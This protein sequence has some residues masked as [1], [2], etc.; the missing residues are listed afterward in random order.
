MPEIL[1]IEDDL[2]FAR[3]V[4]KIMTPHGYVIHHAANGLDGL[5]LARQIT[6]DIILLDMHL[7]DLDGKAIVVTLRGT[8]KRGT[9]PIVALTA[10][11]GDRAKRIALALGCEYFIS[12]PIDTRAFPGQIGAIIESAHSEAK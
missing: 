10:E 12:K 5:R 11:S 9:I 6:A 8:I 2:K 7:P 3:M 1:L 4:E